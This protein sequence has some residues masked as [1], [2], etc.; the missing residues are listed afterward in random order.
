M[1]VYRFKKDAFIERA[2]PKDS[3]RGGFWL[4]RIEA[5]TE[6]ALSPRSVEFWRARDPELL[7]EVTPVPRRPAPVAAAPA[8]VEVDAWPDDRRERLRQTI[9]AALT[10]GATAG[11][12][13]ALDP[14][15]LPGADPEDIERLGNPFTVPAALR[16]LRRLVPAK[17][18]RKPRV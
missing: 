18:G 10:G 3:M 8:P 12:V 16:A 13:L 11:D 9:D 17:R 7:E 6:M 2:H 15:S 4:E 14:A 1:T 5:G